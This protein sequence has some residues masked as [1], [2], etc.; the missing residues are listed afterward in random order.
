VHGGPVEVVAGSW[1]GTVVIIE[2]PDVD[3]HIDGDTILVDGVPP[4]YDPVR[5]AAGCARR[6][7]PAGS[8]RRP[9][10]PIATGRGGRRAG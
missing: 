7:T 8:A 1:P 6:W 10:T 4:R 2:F 9:D 3:Q 5:T